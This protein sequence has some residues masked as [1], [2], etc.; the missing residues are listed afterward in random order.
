MKKT[1]RR[2][3]MFAIACV[4]VGAVVLTSCTK[5]DEVINNVPAMEM[6]V[7]NLPPIRTT[8]KFYVWI[9]EN[10]VD[11]CGNICRIRKCVPGVCGEICAVSISKE[12]LE[13]TGIHVVTK[14]KGDGTIGG[15]EI[16][17]S[18]MPSGIKNSFLKYV[19]KGIITFAVNCPITD[20]ELLAVLTTNHIPAGTYPIRLEKNHFVI[21]ISE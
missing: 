17:I 16:E 1:F 8:L 3:A 4:A 9:E 10:T 21:T 18:N 20:P 11:S 5:D 2:L 13:G 14:P 7:E 12:E 15:L 6:K 19:E